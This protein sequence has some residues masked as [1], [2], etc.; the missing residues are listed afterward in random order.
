MRAG[1]CDPADRADYDALIA[2]APGVKV[3]DTSTYQFSKGR[4]VVFANLTKIG[5]FAN[6]DLGYH[7]L[8]GFL[9]A[10]PPSEDLKSSLL[11]LPAR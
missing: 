2:A 11:G 7:L 1:E 4:V 10:H 8:E 9:G 6:Q 5:D 3:G